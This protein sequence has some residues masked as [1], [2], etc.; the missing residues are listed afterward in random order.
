MKLKEISAAEINTFLSWMRK[1]DRRT[2]RT[3]AEQ[4][5]AQFYQTQWWYTH[6]RC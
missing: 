3:T 6:F 2:R 1:P 5:T 4:K